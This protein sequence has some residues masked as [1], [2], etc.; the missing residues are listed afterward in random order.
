MYVRY[1][2]TRLARS[3]TRDVVRN[4][5]ETMEPREILYLMTHHR[6]ATNVQRYIV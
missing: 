4:Y 3:I 2:G 1:I 5:V 6:R